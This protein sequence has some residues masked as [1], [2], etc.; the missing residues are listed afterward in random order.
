VNGQ[1]H[2]V[3]QPHK[4]N[5]ERMKNQNETKI[6]NKAIINLKPEAADIRNHKSPSQAGWR[7]L[8]S[9]LLLDELEKKSA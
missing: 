9:V 1:K 5:N 8:L 4:R 7:C 6:N 2:A 3:K